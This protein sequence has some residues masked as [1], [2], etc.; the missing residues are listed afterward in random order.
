MLRLAAATTAAALGAVGL[1]V[2]PQ[3]AAAPSPARQWTDVQALI[4][5][6]KGVWT[7][8][9]YPGAIDTTMPK[10]AL[11]GNGDIG[12]T[13]GGGNG[14]KTF[15][16]SKGNY[17]TASPSPSPVSLG[18]VS[19]TPT[20]GAQSGQAANLAL[21]STATASTSHS[22]FP[23]PRAVNGQWA[24]GYEGWVSAVG[25]PQWLRLDLGA[26][27][28]FNRYVIKHDAAAR[29]AETANNTKSWTL[30]TSGDGT[31]WTSVD[32]VTNNTAAITDR[33][34]TQLTARYVR[35]DISEP[36]QGTTSETITNPRARIGQLELYADNLALGSTATASTSH[37]SFP[38]PRAVSGQ[39][40]AG[41]EGWVSTIGKTQWLRLDLGTSKTF[42]RYLIKHDEAA[43]PGNAANNTK[44]W[45]LQ[46]SNDG[47]TWT[48]A[49]T[50]TNNTAASTNRTFTQTTARYVR[51]NITEPTQGTT[52]DTITNPRARIGQLE[53][54]APAGTSQPSVPFREEQNILNAE[55][56]TTMALG[57]VPVTMKT[58]TGADGNYLVTQIKSNGSVPVRLRADTW[59]GSGQPATGFTNTS[60]VSGSTTWATRKTPTSTAWVSEG[61]LATRVI[62]AT[63]T[64][65]SSGATASQTF[66]LPAGQTIRIV[67]AV[68]GG[69]KNATG[70]GA[71]ART[72]V[73]AQTGTT[74]D[75]LY[76]AHA[77]WWKQYWLKSYVD[78]NDSDLERYYYSHLYFMGSAI[79]AGKTAPG[80]YGVWTTTDTPGWY[81]DMHL[82]YNWMANYYGAYSSN[83]ADMFASYQAVV[84]DYLP[85]ARRRAKEDLKRVNN[86]YV[87]NRFPSGGVPGGL[88]FPVGIGPFGSTT[89]DKY[90]NQVCNA[91]FVATQYLEYYDYTRDN[92]WLADSGYPF[93]KEV[94]EF[95][96]H[97]L[98]YDATAQRYNLWGG[99]HEGLWARNSTPDMGMLR[100][101]LTTLINASTT[102]GVDS[103][104]RATWQDILGKL[105]PIATTTYNN[106]T[107]YAI[108][109]PGTITPDTRAI[110]IGDNT[111]NLEFI[112]PGE[113]LGLG[114]SAA[115]RQRAIDTLDAMNSWGQSNSF[116]KVFT[117]A[118]RVGYPAQSLFDKFKA[119]V[120]TSKLA[121]NLRVVDGYHGL[122][123]VGAIESVDSML[124]Q[125]HQGVIRLFPVWP[126]TKDASFVKL[127][128]KGALIVSSEFKAG[129]VTYVDIAPEVGGTVKLLN[130]WPG[131]SVTINKSTGGT[132]SYTET[133]GVIT[134]TGTAG[135]TYTINAP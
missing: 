113:A 12:V 108:A 110:R 54:Y 133:G 122:E 16:V 13:S 86:T 1:T 99:P 90:L 48:T 135:T 44:N 17:W 59:A 9:N 128:E 114:S 6:I 31:T 81:G 80:L 107:V 42:N 125:S 102:L 45:T 76:T 10:T 126:T 69:G 98:E 68:S 70:S 127:R 7:D 115:E 8:Q 73:D 36:T 94:A 74:L 15:Y 96:Q 92:A 109:D 89:D 77:D 60:G 51:L 129:A 100:Y 117:Q 83:R 104:L 72:L 97:W 78:L 55:V 22:S 2:V 37:S 41:Y 27:R 30:Q 58:W 111:I 25:K 101:L 28:S 112:H 47:T 24:A 131:K 79:R 118:A 11:L 88:L 91:L 67:T 40:A 106:K 93:L 84:E 46:T 39:W 87:T 34:F 105:P 52:S 124:M 63:A 29:P 134:F 19:I 66:D 64:T 123:K 130:P 119:Q 53:L 5:P 32:T 18:G 57:G 75:T 35:L 71:A 4:S 120:A 3:A 95:F 103:T 21:G 38:P 85:E 65:A 132:Q 50:V 20:N 26:G 62:G 43:R 23:P 61:S 56:D 82:N 49:D 14:Y 116:P 121:A 33:S